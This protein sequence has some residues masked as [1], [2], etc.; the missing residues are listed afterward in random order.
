MIKA[1]IL[2]T[3]CLGGFLAT[4]AFTQLPSG[5][6]DTAKEKEK[7]KKLAKLETTMPILSGS[8]KVG[9]CEV[10]AEVTFNIET[11][12]T[13]EARLYDALLRFSLDSDASPEATCEAYKGL[14]NPD[15]FIQ[16]T[17]YARAL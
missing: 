16:K 5:G 7:P 1:I 12:V 6:A 9:Y 3:L 8:Q 14:E 17:E 2:P 4:L 13:A 15:I 10:H 11:L